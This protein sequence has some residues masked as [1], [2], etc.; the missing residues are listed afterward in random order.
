MKNDFEVPANCPGG[1]GLCQQSGRAS[2]SDIVGLPGARES[3]LRQ[4]GSRCSC[5][6]SDC[7]VSAHNLAAH[8][9]IIL[10]FPFV[11]V[12]KRLGT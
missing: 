4:V 12:Y 11:V 5:V 10:V 7:C 8:W 3:P 9:S 1:K 2:S 6:R